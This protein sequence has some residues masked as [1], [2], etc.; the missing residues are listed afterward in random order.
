[1]ACPLFGTKLLSQPM[2][3]YYPLDPKD[4]I[5]IKFYLKFKSFHSI[6][7]IWKRH[8]QNGLPSFFCGSYHIKFLVIYILF[9]EFDVSLA[10]HGNWTGVIQVSFIHA[11]YQNWKPYEIYFWMNNTICVYLTDIH[12]H[13]NVRLGWD[14]GI[15]SAAIRVLSRC[16]VATKAAYYGPL[17]VFRKKSMLVLFEI[18]YE[19]PPSRVQ[20]WNFTAKI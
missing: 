8:L 1:M 13:S 7:C 17:H 15:I 14:Q 3:T 10:F 4:Y 18:R 5:S 11:L 16:I 6:R 19:S 2:L 12:V 9:L 20:M